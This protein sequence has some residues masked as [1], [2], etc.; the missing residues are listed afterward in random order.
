MGVRLLMLG[1]LALVIAF[2]AKVPS[3][4][5]KPM[6][7]CDRLLSVRAS[8]AYAPF[9]MKSVGGSAVG[10]DNT[11]IARVLDS[12]GCKYRFVFLPWKRSLY[13]IKTG[14]LDILPSASFTKERTAYGWFSRPYRNDVSGFLVR[15]GEARK[16]NIHD[17][18][19]VVKY[20]LRI[21]HVR[22]AYR[23]EEFKKFVSNPENQQHVI[24]LPRAEMGISLLINGRIDMLIGIPEASYMQAKIRSLDD[25]VEIHPFVLGKEPVRLMYSR[26]TMSPELVRRIDAAIE[27][28]T[29]F[30]W[31]RDLY[32]EKAVTA[33]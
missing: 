14:D 32:G 18:D 5:A 15:R 21:G 24:D 26:Q 9:S 30:A 29:K 19:D 33:N 6:V 12:I 27:R 4:S 11:F 23:G 13:A 3:L 25:K 2:G 1:L 22:S 28:E 16:F 10:L 7:A 8:E 20:D 17:L 31:Y